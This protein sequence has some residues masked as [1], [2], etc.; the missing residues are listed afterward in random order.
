MSRKFKV[1]DRVVVKLEA[2]K[3]Y[4][5]DDYFPVKP[6]QSSTVTRVNLSNDELYYLAEFQT[7][8]PYRE[9]HIEFEE[10]YNSPLYQALK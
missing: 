5:S 7:S 1:G 9:D 6:G 8:G 3:D 10:I 4:Y 2:P